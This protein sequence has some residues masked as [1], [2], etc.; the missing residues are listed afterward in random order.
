MKK[1]FLL[2]ALFALPWCASGKEETGFLLHGAYWIH[3]NWVTDFPLDETDFKDGLGWYLDHR[4][5]LEPQV[6]GSWG[7]VYVQFD[8]LTGQIA[9]DVTDTGAGVLLYPRN[10]INGYKQADFRQ[11]YVELKTRVGLFRIGQM[12]SK[13]GLQILAN[14]GDSSEDPFWDPRYGDLVERFMFAT[15]PAQ[16]FSKAEWAR[17]LYLVVGADLVYRDENASLIDG[18]RAVEGIGAVFYEKA[19]DFYGV[20]VAYRH[21]KYDEGD[22]LKA[23][24]ADIFLKHSFD[25]ETWK[26]LVEF[27]GAGVFG[28]TD[29]VTFE[30]AKDG[31]DIAGFGA[32]ARLRADIDRLH[33]KPQIE[34]GFASGDKDPSDQTIHSFTFDPDYHVGMI[35]F[36]E[37]IGRMSA[38]ATDRVSDPAL[39]HQPP[40][41][42]DMAA[43]NGAITNAVY[44]APAVQYSPLRHLDLRILGLVAWS[45]AGL[46]G[47]YTSANNGGYPLSY[48]G[49][50]SKYLGFELDTG[51]AY[52][53]KLSRYLKSRFMVQA[54]LLLGGSAFDDPK[55]E[56][57]GNVY[58]ARLGMDLLF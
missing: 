42:Y 38:R 32:V 50:P 40:K 10:R 17:H 46:Y 3:S 6:K 31:V 21:Q 55:G 23:T 26:L 57:M 5:R 4:L 9:G 43:T 33:L 18:D 14:D 12:T 52:T 45:P 51:A 39:V 53:L 41:G 34:L 13:W 20:Y 19:E 44:I 47:P 25:F 24:A 54:G 1:S 11:G 29:H 27:E 48:R 8:A 7:K 49:S 16:A 36:P 30:M 15:R 37:V 28:Y 35:L 56:S 2:I 58:K 22:L